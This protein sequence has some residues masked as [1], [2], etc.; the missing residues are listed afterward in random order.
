DTLDGLTGV[1]DYGL[2]TADNTGLADYRIHPVG[3]LNFTRSNPRTTAPAAVGGNVK[4]ASFNVL[5]YFTTIDQ[6]GASCAPS[7]TRSDC[8]GAD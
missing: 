4:V 2:A 5:N 1:I 3:A 8:R 6:S 7:G